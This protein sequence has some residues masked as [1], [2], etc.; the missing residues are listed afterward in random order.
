MGLVFAAA[1]HLFACA[2]PI[3]EFGEEELKNRVLPKLASGEWMG[4]NAITESEA[5]SD[6]HALKTSAD[7]DGEEY[8][9]N[10]V[11]SYV[12][13]GPVADIIVVYARTN[14]EFG[15]L[16]LSAFAVES[17]TPGLKIGQTIQ[18]M[19]LLSAPASSV[20]LTDCRVPASHRL[21]GEGQG[22][23]VFGR[24]MQW[25]RTCLFAGYTGMM[26]RQLQALVEFT[27]Q[28]R[29]FRKPISKNQA[30]SHKLADMKLRLDAARL[31]LYRA[32]WRF[33]RGEDARM[34]ISMAKLAISEAAIE[35]SFNAIHLHGGLG[36][37]SDVRYE[38][39]LRDSIPSTIFSGTSEMQREIIA[40][41]LGL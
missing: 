5:G 41:A 27:R 18:K 16:G 8:I 40:E 11:K 29:Q 7:L 2:K 6:V 30:V 37:T 28:R 1:A 33:D 9:L 32:C 12:T 26:E 24:S 15:F 25:E 34:E 14:P 35:S 31:L 19:G 13:N 3:E 23:A 17:T 22:S 38:M 4:A 10:G 20:Y 21:G 39:D 36:Y